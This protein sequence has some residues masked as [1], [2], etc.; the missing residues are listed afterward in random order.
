MELIHTS[1]TKLYHKPVN[2]DDM[3]KFI[4]RLLDEVH[5]TTPAPQFPATAPDG[6]SRSFAQ[7]S[8]AFSQL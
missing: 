4:R 3:F 8:A 2:V 7:A 5:I 6:K 1:F